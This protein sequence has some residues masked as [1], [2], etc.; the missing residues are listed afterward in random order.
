MSLLAVSWASSPHFRKRITEAHDPFDV[1]SL[2]G[3][4][5]HRIQVYQDIR[6]VWHRGYLAAR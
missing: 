4:V 6:T 2:A 1:E 5:S 3:K